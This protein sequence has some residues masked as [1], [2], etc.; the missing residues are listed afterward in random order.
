MVASTAGDMHE[1]FSV[2][3]EAI[4]C[5]IV[6]AEVFFAP[7]SATTAPVRALCRPPGAPGVDEPRWKGEALTLTELQRSSR[8]RQDWAFDRKE[9]AMRLSRHACKQLRKSL[10]R[11]GL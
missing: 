11:T 2:R 5:K 3:A 10:L 9:C 8:A 4:G 1:A 7:H 6:M